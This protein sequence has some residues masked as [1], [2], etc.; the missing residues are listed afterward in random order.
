MRLEEA[1]EKYNEM[2][3]SIITKYSKMLPFKVCYGSP[4][5]NVDSNMNWEG[6]IRHIRNEGTPLTII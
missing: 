5:V 2:L 4:E 6:N 1:A 3:T